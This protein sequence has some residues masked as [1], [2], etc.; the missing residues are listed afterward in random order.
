MQEPRQ[1][2]SRMAALM[3]RLGREMNGA[4]VE[5]MEQAGVKGVMN[6]GVSIPTIR[7]I[8]HNEPT[9][10]SF[11]RFLYEQQVRELRMVAIHLADPAALSLEELEEWINPPMPT[12]ELYDELAFRLLSRMEEPLLEA[13]CERWLQAEMSDHSYLVLMTLA[14]VKGPLE[15]SLRGLLC[16][17]LPLLGDEP[18]LRSALISLFEMHYGHLEWELLPAT[19]L[20]EAV[21]RELQA[22]FGE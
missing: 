13:F 18:S 6:Y 14:R 20:G 3:G 11:A 5:R 9:D 15:T 16:Q 17:R 22:L 4:V 2:T 8:A 1:H 10:H 21:Q 19:P 12:R 7:Q